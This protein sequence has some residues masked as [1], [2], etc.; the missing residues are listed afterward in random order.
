MTKFR[1]W[2]ERANVF[3]TDLASGY[4]PARAAALLTAFF[5]LLVGLGITVGDLPAKGEAVLAFLTVVAPLLAARAVRRR[6]MPV[7]KLEDNV[8]GGDHN[9]DAQSDTVFVE[10]PTEQVITEPPSAS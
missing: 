1:L 6:V 8:V 2:L 10:L 3:V 4:E 5:T 9:P 7:K